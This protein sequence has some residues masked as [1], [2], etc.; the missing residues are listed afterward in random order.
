MLDN[1]KHYLVISR[2]KPGAAYL[3]LVHRIDRPCSGVLVFAKT[4]KAAARLGESFRSRT[5]EKDYVCIVN[6]RL[7]GEAELNHALR[8]SGDSRVVVLED[9][10]GKG[11]NVKPKRKDAVQA[12]LKYSVLNELTLAG[13]KSVSKQ[14][15]KHQTLLSI[16]LE[17]GRKHQ[18][19][20]QLQHIG[21]P[22]VGDAK[23]GAVQSFP[24]RSIALHAVSLVFEH[25]ITHVRM[26][27]SAPPP[28]AWEKRFG[29]S[30]VNSVDDL[31]KTLF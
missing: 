1:L 23:Y 12:K 13:A 6:G 9:L 30:I 11:E 5:V 24:D 28:V 20:S 3:G 10:S 15:A 31:I 29:K 19:R 2:N 26:R 22:I 4:S 8:K 17:T 7:Q 21:H 14:G 16:K 18:I 27:F 25:P